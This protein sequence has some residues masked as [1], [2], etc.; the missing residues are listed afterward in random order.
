M[1]FRNPLSKGDSPLVGISSI[2]KA[3]LGLR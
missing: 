1:E 3:Q 2:I